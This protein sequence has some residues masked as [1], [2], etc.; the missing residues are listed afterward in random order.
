MKFKVGDRVAVYG[1]ASYYTADSCEGPD[2]VIWRNGHKHS[3]IGVVA[4]YL[5]RLSGD[6]TTDWYEVHSKQCRKPKKKERR[7]LWL[8]NWYFTPI[9]NSPSE[10]NACVRYTKPENDGDY[11]EFV[12]VKPKKENK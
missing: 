6:S 8:K 2:S 11:T 3:V 12:E 7:R 10:A 1:D 5:L 9:L 4:E